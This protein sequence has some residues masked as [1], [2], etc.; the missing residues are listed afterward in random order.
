MQFPW[1]LHLQDTF[2]TLG[3]IEGFIDYPIAHASL[4]LL[5]G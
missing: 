5:S 1:L 4:K 2:E 3:P